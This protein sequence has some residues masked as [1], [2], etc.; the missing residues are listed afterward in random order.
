M[1]LALDAG[2]LLLLSN[3]SLRG[4]GEWRFLALIP[5]TLSLPFIPVN[6]AR[7]TGGAHSLFFPPKS[8]RLAGWQRNVLGGSAALLICCFAI[9]EA[10]TLLARSAR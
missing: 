4:F 9:L 2:Y 5:V 10:F 1:T 8:A 3:L 6:C 7:I